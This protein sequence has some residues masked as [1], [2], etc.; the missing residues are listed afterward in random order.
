MYGTGVVIMDVFDA[1]NGF[2]YVNYTLWIS[3]NT[4]YTH[5]QLFYSCMKLTMAEST[6]VVLMGA[7]YSLALDPTLAWVSLCIRFYCVTP[8]DYYN[9]H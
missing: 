4:R 2:L 8:W 9:C 3:L 7:C 1:I 6:V 5:T